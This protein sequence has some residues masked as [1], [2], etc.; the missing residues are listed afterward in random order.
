MKVG[1]KI[2]SN[3]SKQTYTVLQCFKA[4]GQSEVC[5]ASSDK[6][7]SV[8]FIKRFLN[9]KYSEKPK[10][11]EQCIN[12]ENDKRKIYESINSLTLPGASCSYVFDFFREKTF[13]YVVTEKI[14]GVELPCKRL[15]ETLP[16]ED[17]LFLFRMIV[18]AFLSFERSNIIHADIKPDNIFIEFNN[19][20]LTTRVIDFESAFFANEP[21][22]RGFIV[23]TEPYYSP[24]LASYNIDNDKNTFAALSPKSDIFALGLILYE[25]LT[26]CYPKTSKN[27]YWYEAAK[28]G[29]K[30]EMRKEWSNALK[31][32]LNSMLEVQPSRRPSIKDIL[33]SLKKLDDV[34]FP[35]NSLTCPIVKVQRMDTK[36]ALV[37][38]YNLSKDTKLEFH[39]NKED[40]SLYT[41]EFYIEDDDVDLYM[42]LIS[43]DGASKLYHKI[44][45]VSENRHKKSKRPQIKIESGLVSMLHDSEDSKIYFTTDGTTPS[46]DSCLYIEPFYVAENTIIKAV[47]KVVGYNLSDPTIINSSSKIKMS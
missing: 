44:I 30:I 2:Y 17:R 40:F 31:N 47:A 10:I 29:K 38:L 11:K 26:G 28:Q 22:P 9:I 21:P 7:N 42:K 27:E 33:L 14:N 32:L 16:I 12:F 45:S 5:F 41:G 23:G 20:Y 24:E 36:K 15:A 4:G 37:C 46:I 6:S 35:V 13:Y 3:N 18:Y 39:V 34:S 1:E 19:N 25:L 8:F 43:R